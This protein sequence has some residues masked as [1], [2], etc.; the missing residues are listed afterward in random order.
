MRSEQRST[1]CASGVAIAAVVD[2]EAAFATMIAATAAGHMPQ[3]AA[4]QAMHL[5]QQRGAQTEEWLE[6]LEARGTIELLAADFA[7][8]VDH[9]YRATDDDD[10]RYPGQ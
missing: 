6:I 2:G 9:G 3:A 1:Y 5:A 4:K 8:I 7:R 10:D